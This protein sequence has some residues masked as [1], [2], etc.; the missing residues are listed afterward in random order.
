VLY[1]PNFTED[2]RYTLRITSNDFSGNKSGQDPYEISFQ[3][4]NEFAVTISDPYPNPSFDVVNFNFVVSG[5]DEPKLVAID[6]YSLNGVKVQSLQTSDGQ[7]RVGNNTLT[8]DCKGL[9][10][11]FLPAGIYI[12]RT[13]F[14][15]EG[16]V[17]EKR[18]KISIAK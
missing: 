12:Y 17:S 1:K 5:N 6:I 10:G 4:T 15:K 13:T 14:H 2:G 3:V 11:N 16:Q 7:L 8:W 9:N 18:G